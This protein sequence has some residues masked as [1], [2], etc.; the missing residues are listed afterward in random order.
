MNEGKTVARI[1][2][3]IWKYRDASLDWLN[4]APA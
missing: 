3:L 4:T 1:A 2:K